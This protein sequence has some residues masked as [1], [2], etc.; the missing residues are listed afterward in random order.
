MTIDELS[1]LCE[2]AWTCEGLA[3]KTIHAYL[4]VVHRAE[5]LLSER[6]SSIEAATAIEVREL[7]ERWPRTRSSRI[8]LRVALARAWEVLERVDSPAGA[9]PV[10]SK[11]RYRCRALD[12]AQARA[13]AREARRN[14]GPAGLAV[15]LG[16]YAGLRREEIARLRWSDVRAGWLHVIGKGNVTAELPIHPELERRL[17]DVRRQATSPYVFPGRYGGHAT[18]TTVW[19]WCRRIARAAL[20][21]DVPTHVLR[22][23]AIATLN[24]CTRDLRAAQAFARHASPETTVIYTRVARDRL[25][26]AVAAIDYGEATTT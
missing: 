14:V 19:T 2:E 25:V 1:K 5:L 12:D 18:P 23:T 17:V 16:L 22:H 7:A 21:V 8:Q 4:L 24:D 6:G 20:G 3:A 9:V 10:P 26:A 13:I 11:P 15:L